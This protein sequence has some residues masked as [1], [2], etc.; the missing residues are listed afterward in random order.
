MAG[1]AR[2]ERTASPM[3]IVSIAVAALVCCGAA[4]RAAVLPATL[5]PAPPFPQ[6]LQQ[7]PTIE[8]IAPGVT[9]G[10]YP[11]TTTAGPVVVRIVAVDT[12][13]SDV[14]VG[15]VLAH[16]TLESH[17]ETVGSMAK[18]TGAVA[19]ING[20]YYDI[21]ATNR[22]TNIVIR[23]GT[24]LQM[25]RN[26]YALA[27]TRD[28]AAHVAEFSF[29]GQVQVGDRTV[30]LDAIDRRPADAGTTLLTP[31][32]GGVPP[33]DNVTL[34]SLQ[35]L[36]GTPPLARYRVTGIADNL[37]AQ[38]PGYYLA[39]GPGALSTAG[40]PNPGDVVSAGGDLSPLGLD[41]IATAIGGGPLILHGGSWIDDPDGPNGGEY[42]KRIP[43][44][45]AAIATDGRL[46]LI[47]VDGRQ[48][49]VS[50]GLTR[51]E[52]ASLMRALGAS[53]GL[54]FDGGGSSTMS[55]RR[56]GD[57]VSEIVNSPSDRIERPVGN[58][59]FVYSTAPVGPAVRLVAQPGIVRAVTG[60]AVP[61]RIAAVDAANHVAATGAVSEN[62]E[63]PS[64]GQ[65]R[66]GIFYAR[67]AGSGRI[68]LHGGPL[69]GA[70]ELNVLAAPARLSIEPPGAN[71]DNRGTLQ[72]FAHAADARGYPVALPKTLRWSTSSGS[73]ARDGLFHAATRNARITVRVANAAVQSLVTV[74]SHEVALP[75]AERARF[76]S[77]PH[78]G[79]GHVARDS[80]CGSCV[81]LAYAFAGNERAAYAVSDLALPPGTIGISFDVLD[82]GSA[83]RLRA[84]VRNAINEDTLLT[85]AVLDAP[86]WRHVTVRFPPGTQAARLRA[87]YVLPPRGMQVS[88]GQIQLRNVRAVVAGN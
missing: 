2:V 34:A 31:E 86:G 7:A 1:E 60:A 52:F 72:L 11:M 13:R 50:V 39:I 44:T 26:R 32:Y 69:K 24:L 16:D 63:P 82:D 36:G 4:A 46:F 33:L 3:K 17:G 22:P 41:T 54:A 28:G 42:D 83:S 35:L 18:R 77:I 56:L 45:G 67:Q 66:N 12:H 80:Q 37:S 29:M 71:V 40:V 79:G 51:R 62:V 78:G 87:L 30:S 88:N 15:E 9:F 59:L 58:G 47:E 61:L 14:K 73:I 43:C 53:E 57:A 19:G 64:L 81:T 8:E 84:A 75:F 76:T 20:D 85:A 21:G 74:G 38:P 48:P 27:L 6:I 68:A 70:I 25:P 10:E 49:S 5:A 23:N 65:V 55:V